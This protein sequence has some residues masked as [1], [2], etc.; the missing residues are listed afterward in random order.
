VW[1]AVTPV[2]TGYRMMTEAEWEFAARI[3]GGTSPRTFSWGDALPPPD[4]SENL[5]DVSARSVLTTTIPAYRDGH[6]VSAPV[7]ALPAGP[8][9][10]H[11]L[12][13]NVAEWCHDGYDVVAA[14]ESREF[15]DPAGN[16][17]ASLR[18]IRGASWMHS[19]V[20]RLRAA[21]RDYGEEPRPDVGFRIARYLT[22]PN[23]P[24][25]P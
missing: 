19:G 21:Y 6:A 7:G 17:R 16:P 24:G 23:S 1:V 22:P 2:P 11:D 9:G 18:S 10:A 13:G 3:A 4:A 12:G 5:A 20:A 14:L 15:I 25:V 8:S